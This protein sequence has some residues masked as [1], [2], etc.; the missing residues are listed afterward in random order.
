[1]RFTL[2]VRPPAPKSITETIFGFTSRGLFGQH[3]LIFSTQLCIAILKKRGDLDPNQLSFLLRG[4]RKVC[5]TRHCIAII[6][7]SSKQC[8]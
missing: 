1:M 2:W 5:P 6:W 8:Q 3:S 7:R 4:P